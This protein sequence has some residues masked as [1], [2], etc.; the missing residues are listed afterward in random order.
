MAGVTPMLL[1]Q[2]INARDSV[3]QQAGGLEHPR[4]ALSK[5]RISA[6]AGAESDAR[7]AP[8]PPK[9]PDLAFIQHHWPELSP[10]I[11]QAITHVVRASVQLQNKD[12]R[13]QA[14]RILRLPLPIA[15]LSAC[16]IGAPKTASLL[17]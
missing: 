9:D 12:A 4:L 2:G 15:R 5:T 8:E 11:R 7:H 3:Q 16:Q 10:E 1:W 17:P 6:E 13:P 14:R